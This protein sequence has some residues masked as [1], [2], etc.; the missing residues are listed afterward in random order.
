MTRCMEVRE[1]LRQSAPWAVIARTAVYTP[2][3]H[4]NVDDAAG[5]IAVKALGSYDADGA[6]HDVVAFED[7]Q[8]LRSTH[9]TSVTLSRK[10]H[11]TSGSK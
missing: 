1:C 6:G 5:L 9:P 11:S 7:V 10:S 4:V 3:P 8:D 2:F